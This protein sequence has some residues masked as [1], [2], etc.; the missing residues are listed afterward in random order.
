MQWR[1]ANPSKAFAEK[2]MLV[3]SPLWIGA[4]AAIVKYEWYLAFSPND[5]VALGLA[6]LI[7]CI[8]APVLLANEQERSLPLRQ[9]FIFKANVFVAILSYIGNHFYTHYFYN[10]LGVRYT[11]PLGEGEGLEINRVPVSM[12][13]MTHVY[14]L[15]YHILV[16]PCIRAVKS[17]FGSISQSRA[18]QLAA[19]TLFVVF[20]AIL[21]AFAETLT[22]SSFPYYTYPD[23]SAM[24]TK[25]S[26]FYA[27][28]FVVTFPWFFRMDEDP[29]D[30]W[31]AGRAA[32]EAL[33]AMMVVLLCADVWR[34]CLVYLDM[35]HSSDLPYAHV[36]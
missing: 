22:V 7:P 16:T 3:F 11:G 5:Y 14:F 4:M 34:L 8:T 21:T 6:L 27:T 13:L 26:V 35:A 12:F 2:F 17:V 20:I 23:R 19:M 31:S 9:R 33:A 36:P 32:V 30:L 10:I 29:E 24:L 28:Y 18:L 1:A 15:T 25:G